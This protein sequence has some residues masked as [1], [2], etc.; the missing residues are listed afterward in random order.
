MKTKLKIIIVS[1]I[2]FILAIAPWITDEYAV[3]KVKTYPNF[4]YQHRLD[5][6]DDLEIY[7][8]KTPFC[9]WVTTYEG[10]WFVC[11]WHIF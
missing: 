1:I 2:L 3:S 5:N 6:K 4:Q 10:G 9:R 8:T 11:F 7:V